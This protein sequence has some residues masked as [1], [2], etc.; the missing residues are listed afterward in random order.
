[1]ESRRKQ[2]LGIEL[3]RRGTVSGETIERALQYQVEHPNKRLGDILY[4][5]KEVEPETLIKAI[6]DIMGEKGIFIKEDT[7]KIDTNEYIAFDTMKKYKVVPFE[8]DNGKIKVAFAD[9]VNNKENIKNV[10]MLFLNKGLIMEPYIALE[11][12][13]DEY[14]NKIEEKNE[15][16]IG[17][18]EYS[19]SV[20]ELVDNVIKL[21]IEDRASDI[22]IEPQSDSLRIR[23]RIDGQLFTMANIAKDKQNQIIGRLKAIS[24]ISI[25]NPI[26][27]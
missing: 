18:I 2:P 19:A 22:H 25:N 23:F 15:E 8:L 1:M 16:T 27:T 12:N 21:A 3:A 11:T 17:N 4:I 14:F 26:D 13:I 9:I 6:G 24:N 10:R 5:L 7:I 20:T